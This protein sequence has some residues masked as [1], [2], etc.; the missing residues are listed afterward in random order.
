DWSLRR[1]RDSAWLVPAGAPEPEGVVLS[2]SLSGPSYQIQAPSETTE[3]E[4]RAEEAQSPVS[5][6]SMGY[7]SGG[8]SPDHRRH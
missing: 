8:S 3:H 4:E 7:G 1:P 2:S 5:G 6:A